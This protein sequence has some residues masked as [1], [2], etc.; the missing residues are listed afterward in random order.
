MDELALHP[1]DLDLQQAKNLSDES[2]VRPSTTDQHKM[3]FARTGRLPASPD[4][5]ALHMT[6]VCCNAIGHSITKADLDNRRGMFAMGPQAP[7]Q[8]DDE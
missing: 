1:L 2:D 4:V 5:K 3:H 8:S 7:G 6:V